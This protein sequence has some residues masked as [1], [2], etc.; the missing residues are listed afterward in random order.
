MPRRGHVE[1]TGRDL[2][3]VCVERECELAGR[4]ALDMGCGEQV[5]DPQF[6]PEVWRRDVKQ[7]LVL[8]HVLA[9]VWKWEGG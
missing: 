3:P 9:V 1:D 8:S 5:G 7:V 4:V 6:G 2:L